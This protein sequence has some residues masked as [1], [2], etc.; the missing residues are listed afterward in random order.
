MSHKETTNGGDRPED[1]DSLAFFYIFELAGLLLAERFFPPTVI[2][3][4]LDHPSP[5]MVPREDI[6][7]TEI[8]TRSPFAEPRPRGHGKP[9][10]NPARLTRLQSN[11]KGESAAK[12]DYGGY[13]DESPAQRTRAVH[14]DA[15]DIGSRVCSECRSK[16]YGDFGEFCQGIV[17]PG[18][19]RFEN[20]FDARGES[21]RLFQKRLKGEESNP[22]PLHNYLS[23]LAAVHRERH[24]ESH[25]SILP[26]NHSAIEPR[27]Q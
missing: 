5:R 17:D 23:P 4:P 14:D 10:S 7:I 15:R 20:S 19:L 24:H 21:R 13:L 8:R 3:E 26:V 18:R 25:R 2:F 6:I 1:T 11:S 16:H 22:L 27:V 12:A 9:S